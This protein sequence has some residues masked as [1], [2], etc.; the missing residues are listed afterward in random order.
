MRV[1]EKMTF[2]RNQN[3]ALTV[4][5]L[6]LHHNSYFDTLRTFISCSAQGEL[7]YVNFT[8]TQLIPTWPITSQRAALH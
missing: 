5:D 6:T 1:V 3:S 4:G 7:H 8:G 2:L